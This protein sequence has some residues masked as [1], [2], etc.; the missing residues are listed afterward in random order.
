MIENVS[1][2]TQSAHFR[3]RIVLAMLLIG[4]ALSSV[5]AMS[6]GYQIHLLDAIASRTPI[7]P[8]AAAANDSRQA[9]ISSLRTLTYFATAISFLAWMYQSHKT[10]PLLGARSLQYSP[11]WAIGSFFVPFLSLFRPYSVMSEIWRA[12][13]PSPESDQSWQWENPPVL[14]RWWWGLFIMKV[15]LSRFFGQ[16]VPHDDSV[17][18]ITRIIRETY[19]LLGI[20]LFDIPASVVA[21]FV[22]WSVEARQISGLDRLLK[23]AAAA[24]LP[25]QTAE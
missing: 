12:S 15:V 22:I 17:D 4:M 7:N 6:T 9:A 1:S 13:D 21:M 10:L 25:E 16:L 23:S 2:A 24:A 5:G 11:G 8:G 3:A 14:L 18:K 19:L 20:E